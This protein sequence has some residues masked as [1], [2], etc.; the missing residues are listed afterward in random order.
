MAYIQRENSEAS[1]LAADYASQ[2]TRDFVSR[3]DELIDWDKRAAGEGNFFS[4]LLSKSGA[5][6][7][8]DVATG[9]GFHAVQL[10]QAGFSVLACDGSPTMVERARSNV[11][12]RGLDIPV[13]QRDWLELDHRSL[14]TFDA[15][16][17]LGSSMCHVFDKGD[18]LQVLRR[19]RQLLKPGGLLLLDQRN[20]RAI[21]AGRYRASGRYYYCG[22]NAEVSLGEVSDQLCEFIYTFADGACWRLRVY[23]IL[24][25]ELKGE[26][27]EAG[28]CWPR[29]FGDFRHIYD[30]LDCDFIIHMAI[31]K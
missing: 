7:V 20:F 2:Y 27:S 3:W 16:L 23:P 13:L 8:I 31:A 15:V 12:S 11:K 18:R 30:P 19:F 26:I 21:R 10:C 22:R 17:C 4:Q 14:G 6:T 1:A 5:E 25:E 29:S 24:P 9:S 28:F